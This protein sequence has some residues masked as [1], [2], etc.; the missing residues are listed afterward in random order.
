MEK[1]SSIPLHQLRTFVEIIGGDKSL[2][3]QLKRQDR[4]NF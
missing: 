4:V 1:L 3:H 2:Q